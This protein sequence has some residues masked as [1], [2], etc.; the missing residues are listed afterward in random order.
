MTDRIPAVQVGAPDPELR[1]SPIYEETDEDFE[2]AAQTF[3]EESVCYFNDTAYQ[4]DQYVCSGAELLRC[5]RGVWLQE[6]SCD[7]DNP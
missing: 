4:H 5:S 3:P 1:N 7:P 6:G 2:V